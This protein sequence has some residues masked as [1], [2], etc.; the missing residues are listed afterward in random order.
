MGEPACFQW[1]IPAPRTISELFPAKVKHFMA[2]AQ[3]TLT[4]PSASVLMSAAAVDAILKNK[5]LTSGSLYK[6]IEQAASTGIITK[7]MATLAHDVRLDAND[8]RHADDNAHPPSDSDA[9]RCFDF[10][11]AIAEMI[12]I[13]P[14]RVKRAGG[15]SET[16]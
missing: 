7:E 5:G 4:S 3:E 12:Y 8:E 16:S 15:A 11:E 2:Q 13:L 9:Q 1:I 14:A 6:R 10:A